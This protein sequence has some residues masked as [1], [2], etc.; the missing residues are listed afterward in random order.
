MFGFSRSRGLL[1]LLGVRLPANT[2]CEHLV[3]IGIN[4]SIG[5]CIVCG[6]LIQGSVRYGIFISPPAEALEADRQAAAAAAAQPPQNS[7][8]PFTRPRKR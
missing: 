5:A 4:S 7:S 1:G 3:R 2:H 6:D 8:S